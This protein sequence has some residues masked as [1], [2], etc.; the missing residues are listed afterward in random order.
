MPPWH[1]L[2]HSPNITLTITTKN[3]CTSQLNMTI[4]AV[5]QEALCALRLLVRGQNV[6][7]EETEFYAFYRT[8][9]VALSHLKWLAIALH[10]NHSL[11]VT[12]VTI[13]Y[14]HL[15]RGL[16]LIYNR[17]SLINNAHPAMC[18]CRHCDKWEEYACM[19]NGNTNFHVHTTYNMHRSVH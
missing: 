13:I 1:C 11:A 8:C 14:S 6:I 3:F 10:R 7:I 15:L 2:A 19:W 16:Q 12:V 18:S 5:D 9:S 4:V 17:Y